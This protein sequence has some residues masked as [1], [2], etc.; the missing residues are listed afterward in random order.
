MYDSKGNLIPPL[1]YSNGKTQ[2]DIV[3]ELVDLFKKYDILFLK[4]GV[5]TGKSAIALHLIKYF[6]KGIIT[7]PTKILEKQYHEDY[8]TGRYRI[9]NL[10][11]EHIMGRGNFTCLL[12]PKYKCNNKYLPC[13]RTLKETEKRMHVA[14]ICPYWSPIY[15]FKPP[16]KYLPKNKIIAYESVEGVKYYLK[17]PIPCGY[18]KQFECYAEENI[19]IIFNLAKWEI[20]TWMKRKPLVPIEIIDEGDE[21][22]DQLTYKTTL[23]TRFFTGLEKR[24]ILKPELAKKIKESFK[25]IIKKNK[26]FEGFLNEKTEI[27][28]FLTQLIKKLDEVTIGGET[29]EKLN[30]LRLMIDYSKESYVKI[31]PRGR[32][33]I[34]IPRPDLTLKEIR[35]RSGKLLIMSATMHNKNVLRG[36][37][38]VENPIIIEA[39]KRNPGTLYLKSLGKEM[40][41]NH[42]TWE[43]EKF[44]QTYWN[45]LEEII[46]K[47]TPPILIQVHAFK[48][49]PEKYKNKINKWIKIE[50]KK[51]MF[52]TITDRGIDLRDDLCRS[53]VI[54]KYPLPDLS[55]VVLKVMRQ[56]I[57]E[58]KFWYYVN[59]MADRQLIQQCGRAVRHNS[60]W[61]EIWTTD[62]RVLKRLPIIW[63]GEISLP[64]SDGKY[65]KL[66][67]FTKKLPKGDSDG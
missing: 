31:L 23:S 50:G 45:T 15:P 22:L 29:I 61:C 2:E 5:G 34:F 43:D 11:I 56:K 44:R 36:V 25:K 9:G 41:V 40:K 48:Y 19:A 7:T 66:K 58:Q 32:M 24:G 57:G 42:R 46:K 28:T 63:R 6:G 1:K 14:S 30:R 10:K 65:K 37:F 55:D 38:G 21:F 13:T 67:Y 51:V 4:G 26:E 54:L 35:K 27:I 18:Y 17:A 20:E 33:I 3:N 16:R 47:A 64:N 12:N 8:Y 60:D 53:I 39:E 49:L 62:T 52:S 59:D